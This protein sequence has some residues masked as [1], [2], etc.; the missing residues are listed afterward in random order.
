MTT[1]HVAETIAALK[2]SGY[3]CI[4]VGRGAT[5]I[6]GLVDDSL[7]PGVFIEADGGEIRR[8]AGGIGDIKEAYG[9]V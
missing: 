3:V 6:V 4:H 2:H 5:W 8:V 1:E 9:E 7:R